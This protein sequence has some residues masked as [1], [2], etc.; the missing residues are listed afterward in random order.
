[1]AYNF[2]VILSPYNGPGEVKIDTQS[3]YGYWEYPSGEEGGGLWF[4][5]NELIDY[6]GAFELPKKVIIALRNHGFILDEVYDS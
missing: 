2:N 3:N 6:D 5:N 1:M 4:E